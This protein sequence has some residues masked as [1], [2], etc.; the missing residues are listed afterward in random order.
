MRAALL[1]TALLVAAPAWGGPVEQQCAALA[2]ELGAKLD[3][4]MPWMTAIRLTDLPPFVSATSDCI[5]RS[6]AG[7]QAASA[8]RVQM[9]RLQALAS[10]PPKPTV[11]ENVDEVRAGRKALELLTQPETLP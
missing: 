9:E 6:F 8:M 11:Q 3:A 1:A 5:D 4:G 2:Q 7:A 10:N